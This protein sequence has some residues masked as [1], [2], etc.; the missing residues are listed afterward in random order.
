MGCGPAARSEPGSRAVQQTFRGD[1]PLKVIAT[2]G[3]V[4]DIARAVGGSHV[5][6]TQIMGAGVDPHLYKATRDDV[7]LLMKGDVVFY[8]GLMLEGKM[9]DVLV[10]L[11]RGRP[12]VAVTSEMD[13]ANLLQP[14]G[15]GGHADPHVWMDVAAWSTCVG[16]V[17]Q[18][19]ADFDPPHATDYQAN[20][21]A[22]QQQ[23]AELHEYGRQSLS[24]IPRERRVLI[25]SHDAFNYFGRA[26]DLEVQ[27][28]QG[29]STES[30]AGLQR[31]NELVALIS[32]RGIRSVF[33]ESSVSR[34]N[35]E[36]LVEGVAQRGHVVEIGG[37]LYS[38]AMGRQGTYE[39]SYIGMLDHNITL[40]TRA[41]GGSAPATGL[42]GRLS[43]AAGP[44]P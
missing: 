37:E 32:D 35:I 30:E 39:G 38:D 11:A 5:Q 31:I 17:A 42:H 29:L 24:S 40:V 19:L 20:A 3:M 10:K 14:E 36:A 7:Q 1:Y 6:V 26:Y 27:G 8:C 18:T 34:K 12:V 23:L 41:L 21:Q 43:H 2:V 15:S 44:T 13:E 4:A 9:S 33:V 22:Y 25:T 28:V 16:T